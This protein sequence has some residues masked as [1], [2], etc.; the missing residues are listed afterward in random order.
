M[1]DEAIEGYAAK[2]GDWR[3]DVIL[4]LHE[5]VSTAAP[6]ATATIKWA[7][8]VWEWNGPI[9]YAKGFAKHVNF[10]FWRGTELTDPKGLL[11]GSGDRMMHVKITA[12][13]DVREAQ[14]AAWV[15]EALRLNETLGNPTKRR[16]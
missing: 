16:A 11:E 10:G 13:G 3:G 2:L 9:A 5:I 8:P 7:Q 4:E 15:E 1:V 12:P 6:A 14:F